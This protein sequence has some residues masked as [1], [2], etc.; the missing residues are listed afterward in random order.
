MEKEKNVE[1][2]TEEEIKKRKKGKNILIV[3]MAIIMVLLVGYIVFMCIDIKGNNNKDTLNNTEKHEEVSKNENISESENLEEEEDED[4]EEPFEEIIE[5][6]GDEVKKLSFRFISMLNPMDNRCINTKITKK[7]FSEE[8]I[9]DFVN[10]ALDE[11]NKFENKEVLSDTE[12]F[13]YVSYDVY[14]EYV[15]RFFGIDDYKIPQNFDTIN[16]NCHKYTNTG[17][18][19]QRYENGPQCSFGA[20]ADVKYED[21]HY[22]YESYVEEG[23]IVVVTAVA[24][25]NYNENIYTNHTEYYVDSSKTVRVEDYSDSRLKRLNYKFKKNN[26]YLTLLS[27]EIK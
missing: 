18:N 17:Q 13:D 21:W 25:Y 6:S 26:G 19:I 12:H 27:I 7:C 16:Q 11:D 10:A 24:V 20:H 2:L 15:K 23:N 3:V 9:I 4:I 8:E 14:K 5:M 1:N 22:N